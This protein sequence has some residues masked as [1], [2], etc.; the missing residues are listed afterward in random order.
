VRYLLSAFQDLPQL[1]CSGTGGT[2]TGVRRANVG[3]RGP[4]EIAR[5]V[6]EPLNTGRPERNSRA[7]NR[8]A[9]AAS[10][11]S[12]RHSNTVVTLL[13][14][15]SLQQEGLQAAH[16][17]DWFLI[18]RTTLERD[19]TL[20]TNAH[21]N[22]NIMRLLSVKGAVRLEQRFEN[23][24]E[25]AARKITVTYDYNLIH[26]VHNICVYITG[27][28]HEWYECSCWCCYYFCWT[29]EVMNGWLAFDD[30]WI[31]LVALLKSH[32][33]G[34]THVL[35]TEHEKIK[36]PGACCQVDRIEMKA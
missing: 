1:N 14:D 8:D 23:I 9:F 3:V 20:F 5:D 21:N 31:K 19:R 12:V 4:G 28:G 24:S 32:F 35:K 30:T 11:P 36:V 15:G 6:A 22:N 16:C 7:R 33:N 27:C 25:P 13:W 10:H 26:N 18:K 17:I 29:I 34:C 2:E